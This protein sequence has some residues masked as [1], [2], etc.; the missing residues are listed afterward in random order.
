MTRKLPPQNSS[1]AAAAPTESPWSLPLFVTARNKYPV[2]IIMF[3]VAAAQYLT[4]NHYQIFPARELPMT[5]IDRAIPFLPYTF[6]IYSSEYLY[7]SLIYILSKDMN[8]LSKYIYSFLGLQ[9]VSVIIFWVWPTVYPRDLFPLP[10]DMN[11]LTY[12]LFQ[13]L[14]IIDTP[15]NC[16]PSLHVSSV[17][18]SAFIYLD[19]QREKFPFFLIWG[20]SIAFSTLTTKQHYLVD[21][22]AGFAFAI[23]SY[24]FFHKFVKYHRPS[25][26]NH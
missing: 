17:L 26:F 7:F 11:P 16:C 9:T 8:N 12:H 2:G 19:E 18:L 25:T 6:W 21:V 20:L 13:V 3:I 22:L 24:W 1:S 4:V 5:A 14:R 23:G 15:A 10:E